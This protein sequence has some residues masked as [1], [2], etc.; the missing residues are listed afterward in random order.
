MKYELVFTAYNRPL[1]LQQSID[2]W[3]QVRGINQWPVTFHIEP[4]EVQNEILDIV[5]QLNTTVTAVVNPEKLGVLVNPWNA[6][7]SAFEAGADFVVIAEDD[8]AVSQ[9]TLEFFSWTAEE[10]SGSKNV[11]C[12][13][14]FSQFGGP[15]ANEIM[16]HQKFSPLVWGIWRDR[17]E[18]HLRDTWD[19]DY[20]T[21]KADGSEAGWDWN[22]NRILAQKDMRVIGP[23]QSRSDHLGEFDGTHMTP[24]FY[25][26]SRGID[27]TQTR[28]RQRY[29][30]V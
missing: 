11:L 25:A 26:S 18:E 4:S 10:Y 27:F 6:L 30:E 15:K 8:I 17:W 2:S 29:I 16:Q 24:E 19:K 7:N 12:L 22:I 14:A 3:N 1:Y 13:N 21:G 23:L 9:D 20:S 28:G 5:F